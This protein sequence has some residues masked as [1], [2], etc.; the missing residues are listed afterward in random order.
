MHFPWKSKNRGCKYL[1]L[2]RRRRRWRCWKSQG[3]LVYWMKRGSKY[4]R[5]CLVRSF[6]I[7]QPQVSYY[8]RWHAGSG[9]RRGGTLRKKSYSKHLNCI[10]FQN[11][12]YQ[13]SSISSW[14][15]SPFSNPKSPPP[16]PPQAKEPSVVAFRGG[17]GA[18]VT[19]GARGWLYNG[20][21]HLQPTKHL[22]QLHTREGVPPDSSLWKIR[23]LRSFPSNPCKTFPTIQLPHY[24]PGRHGLLLIS[25]FVYVKLCF[26]HVVCPL[27]VHPLSHF[28]LLLFCLLLYF[29]CGLAWSP[30]PHNERSP[31]HQVVL[32]RG[33][34]H[35]RLLGRLH[36]IPIREAAPNFL[37]PPTAGPYLLVMRTSD[38]AASFHLLLTFL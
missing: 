21:H 2:F 24:F 36:L 15:P 38:M 31:T 29:V 9:T 3:K 26:V 30:L 13:S 33:R 4:W 12:D 34:K 22:T 11:F 5:F 19:Q 18:P 1:D 25:S 16:A 27:C 14:T 32:F 6:C 8:P 28:V 23:N 17:L 37:S 35:K 7:N 20:T 10:V